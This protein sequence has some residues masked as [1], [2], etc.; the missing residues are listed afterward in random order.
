VLFVVVGDGRV[1]L[2]RVLDVAEVVDAQRG[3]GE[4]GVNAHR[5]TL[6]G[7]VEH[8]RL[9]EGEMQREVIVAVVLQQ[10]VVH[11]RQEL[12]VSVI[13]AADGDLGVV[14]ATAAAAPAAAAGEC[15]HEHQQH[16]AQVLVRAWYVCQEPHLLFFS[17]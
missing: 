11:L 3:A 9:A 4:L 13:L 14:G 5:A 7:R 15:E 17:P 16:D 2:L 10:Q 12:A 1:G 8:R 6:D